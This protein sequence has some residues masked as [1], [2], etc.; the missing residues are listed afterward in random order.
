MGPAFPAV[1]AGE[2]EVDFVAD[3]ERMAGIDHGFEGI[4]EEFDKNAMNFEVEND[5]AEFVADLVLP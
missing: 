4:V 5:C 3:F 2:A 1:G